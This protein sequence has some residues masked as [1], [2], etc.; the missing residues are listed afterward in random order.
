M[1]DWSNRIIGY[2]DDEYSTVQPGERPVNPRSRAALSDMFDYANDLAK[3]KRRRPADDVL[4]ALLASDIDGE[5]LTVAQFQNFFFLLAVAGN[6]TLRNAIPG[7]MLSLL[8]HPDQHR[9]LLNEPGRLPAAVQEMLRYHTPVVH[10]R[11]TATAATVLGGRSIRAGD[12]VVVFYAAANRDGSVFEDPDRFDVG[13]HPNPHLSFGA[14]PHYCLG[15]SLATMEMEVFFR[16]VLWRF[17]EIELAGDPVRLASS[18]QAG[19][20]RLPVRWGRP[21]S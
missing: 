4:S 3:R 17:P 13:R 18:F 8:E 6:E 14:G 10:F 11:R 7:G 21:A 12:K 1:Y 9:R 2:Q 5:A 20:K 16:A 15:A 19:F